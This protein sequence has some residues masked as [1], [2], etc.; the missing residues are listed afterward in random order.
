M[1]YSLGSLAI[2]ALLLAGCSAHGS[3]SSPV[4]P[5]PAQ[6]NVVNLGVT[7]SGV[8][9][10]TTTVA[11]VGIRLSGESAFTSPKY[12]RVIGYFKGKISTTSQVVS[13]PADTEVRFFNVDSFL[14]HTASFLGD[15]TRNSAP[16]PQSFNGSGT[17]APAGTAIGTTNWSTGALSPGKSSV[18]YN[19]GMP[20]FYMIGCF[21]HYNLDGMRTIIIVK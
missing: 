15:A 2:A 19:T 12:G 3:A 11:K 8:I 6:P 1:R 7:D 9:P 5:A 21:F 17:K 18:L 14:T 13:L 20:G 10:D 16:W 4:M